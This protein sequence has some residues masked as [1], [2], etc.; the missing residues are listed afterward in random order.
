M[1]IGPRLHPRFAFKDAQ[2]IFGG[3]GVEE[4]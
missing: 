3:Q 2:E 4:M 1:K